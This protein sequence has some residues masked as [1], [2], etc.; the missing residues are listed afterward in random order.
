[1]QVDLVGHATGLKQDAALLFE[2]PPELP[3]KAWAHLLVDQP[4]PT[5]G[6][7]DEVVEEVRVGVRHGCPVWMRGP[8]HRSLYGPTRAAATRRFPTLAQC[9]RSPLRATPIKPTTR[10]AS[11]WAKTPCPQASPSWP[12]TTRFPL[13]GRAN[14]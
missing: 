7:E 13:T 14:D 1:K 11:P 6:G 5:L 4:P 2:P 10:R 3:V 9:R 8:L 12:H